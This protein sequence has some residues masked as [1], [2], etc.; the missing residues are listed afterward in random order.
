MKND[1]S[2]MRW[3]EVALEQAELAGKQGEVPVGAVLIRD[4]KLLSKAGNRPISS[5]DPTAHAEI[6]VLRKAAKKEENYRLP[7]ST[8]YVTLEPCTMCVGAIIHAR[9][10]RVVFGA[11]DSKTGALTSV[12]SIGG[13]GLL[14]HT[15][16]ISGGIL[17]EKS[18]S[19]LKD[20]FSSKRRKK[21]D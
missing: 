17:A 19:L 18:S 10:K 21:V 2:D 7:G 12:Y 6:L 16:E 3:M 20:F 8:L 4:D 14:N 13:D 1:E 15:L 9:V 5:N 11:K